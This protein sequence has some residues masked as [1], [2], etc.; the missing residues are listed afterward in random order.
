MHEIYVFSSAFTSLCDI[1]LS[2][3]KRLSFRVIYQ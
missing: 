2:G 3:Q 1:L